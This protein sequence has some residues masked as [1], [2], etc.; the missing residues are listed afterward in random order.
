MGADW[1]SIRTPFYQGTTEKEG[2]LIRISYSFEMLKI[3]VN[4][5]TYRKE[6]E[7]QS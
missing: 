5:P 7:A 3:Q 6:E 4:L 2:V 1:S